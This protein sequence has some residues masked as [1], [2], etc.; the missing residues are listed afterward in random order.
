MLVDFIFNP[1]AAAFGSGS[2]GNHAEVCA[3]GSALHVSG[4]KLRHVADIL[5]DCFVQ[6]G[7]VD[8]QQAEIGVAFIGYGLD[9]DLGQAGKQIIQGVVAVLHAG[10][11]VGRT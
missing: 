6:L 10:E 8:F 9:A 5:V 4:K 3:V 11:A 1:V 2:G 7:L